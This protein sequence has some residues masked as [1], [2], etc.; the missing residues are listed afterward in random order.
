[1]MQAEAVV[2]AVAAVVA[3]SV[4][5]TGSTLALASAVVAVRERYER[6]YGQRSVDTRHDARRA[7]EDF[8][9]SL[10]ELRTSHRAQTQKEWNG[11]SMYV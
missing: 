6:G 5:A 11:R 2:A 1:M 3:L 9:R 8:L 7:S 4:L 10:A